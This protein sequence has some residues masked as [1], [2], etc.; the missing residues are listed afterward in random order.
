MSKAMPII[1][2]LIIV[3]I[4]VGGIYLM[5][6]QKPQSAPAENLNPTSTPIESAVHQALPS[7]II[8]PTQQASVEAAMANVNT[9][10][11]GLKIEDEV[12]GTGTEAKTGDTVTVNYL[13]TLTNGEKFDSSYDRNQPFTAQIGVGQVIKGWDEGIIGMKVGGK[14]KLTIPPSLG[15]GSQSAGSIPPNSTLMFEVEL[16]GIK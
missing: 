9:L 4:G 8:T 1:I 14:R 6:N 16:L 12:V 11:D 3:L 2:V 13:G 7:A 5:A 10:Q 15:Y